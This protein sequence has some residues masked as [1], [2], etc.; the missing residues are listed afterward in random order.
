M[1][2][3]D[4]RP[5]SRSGHRRYG[6]LRRLATKALRNHRTTSCDAEFKIALVSRSFLGGSDR[7]RWMPCGSRTGPTAC[8]A[9]LSASRRTWRDSS[10][11]SRGSITVHG[12]RCCSAPDSKR[13]GRDRAIGAVMRF[14]TTTRC[15]SQVRPQFWQTSVSMADGLSSVALA[16]GAR[17]CRGVA[18]CSSFARALFSRTRRSSTSAG[19]N[20]WS[21]YVAI[22]RSAHSTA[23]AQSCAFWR[24]MTACLYNSSSGIPPKTSTRAGAIAP[25]SA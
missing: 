12:L 13:T 7:S 5:S 20:A 21:A 1:A 14:A 3:S 4:I 11:A 23:R 8:S 24:R 16:R 22:P 10:A 19:F 2:A 25:I 18:A 17:G 15:R 6:M 9:A